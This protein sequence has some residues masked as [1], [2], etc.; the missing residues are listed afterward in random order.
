VIL[1]S[2]NAQGIL[3]KE[4][5]RFFCSLELTNVQARRKVNQQNFRIKNKEVLAEKRKTRNKEMVAAARIAKKVA[6]IAVKAR[7]AKQGASGNACHSIFGSLY[8]GTALD[9]DAMNPKLVLDPKIAPTRETF[10]AFVCCYIP[11]KQWPKV[12]T[13][14]QLT[15]E[16]MN[17]TFP[18]VKQMPGAE[19]FR[20]L[21]RMIHPDRTFQQVT[22]RRG[23]LTTRSRSTVNDA[24]PP[25]IED[26]FGFRVHPN[27][28]L[29]Q[30]LN[31]AYDL[32]KPT[33]RNES[34]INES[35]INLRDDEATFRNRSPV[36][37]ELIELFKAWVSVSCL[38]MERLTPVGYSLAQIQY[39]VNNRLAT[40]E[41][42]LSQSSSE[43][44]D[45]VERDEIDTLSED[46]LLHRALHLPVYR[47]R[48]RP[49]PRARS[50]GS[51]ESN[52]GE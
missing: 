51:E 40:P 2:I 21:S 22:A 23:A 6:R 46:Q 27:N 29:S 42:E 38:V 5:L 44:E 7:A 52:V 9:G 24:P 14:D 25:F 12:I 18:L 45:G 48:G 31:S 16:N 1:K 35:F 15:S 47:G 3:L 50:E 37:S 43:E 11:P 33:L 28:E 32:W 39:H 19:E 34:I 10:P 17:A 20:I 36:H 49:R 26:Q 8:T 13:L 30:M 4:K 41:P